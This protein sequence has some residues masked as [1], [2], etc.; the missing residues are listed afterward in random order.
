MIK[1]PGGGFAERSVFMQVSVRFDCEVAS[2][3]GEAISLLQRHGPEAHLLAGG[4]V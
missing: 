2:S 1:E 3:V 4:I